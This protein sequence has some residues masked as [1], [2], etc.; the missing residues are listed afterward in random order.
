MTFRGALWKKFGKSILR[1]IF[2]YPRIWH[3]FTIYA[4]E[5]KKVATPEEWAKFK[6]VFGCD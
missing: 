1:S 6:K 4:N 3:V 2:L 5:Y